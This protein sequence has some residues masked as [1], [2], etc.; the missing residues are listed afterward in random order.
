MRKILFVLVIMIF[1]LSACGQSTPVP[2]VDDV[3]STPSLTP[4]STATLL[5]SVTPT[6]SITPLPTIPTFTP[7]FDVSTI[8]TVTPAGKAECPITKEEILISLPT[9]KE[10]IPGGD[11]LENEYIRPILNYLNS[12]G[13]PMD[14]LEKMEV[15]YCSGKCEMGELKDMTNDGVDEVIIGYPAYIIYSCAGRKYETIFQEGL[16]T[17]HTIYNDLTLNN[18]PELVSAYYP[19]SNHCL[20]LVIREWDGTEFRV[21]THVG[22]NGAYGRGFEITD[23]NGDDLMEIIIT[24]DILSWISPAGMIPNRIKTIIYG[25]NGES[26]TEVQFRFE[27]PQYRFQAVQDA[28]RE[29]NYKHY[30]LA[31]KLYQSAIFSAKLDWWS[32]ER[33][34]FLDDTFSQQYEPTPTKYPTPIA[35]LAEYP[36]LAA[37]AYYRIVLIHLVQGQESEATTTYNTLQQTFGDDPYAHPYIEMAS[38]FWEAY[39]STHKMYDGCA[40][41]IQYAVEH[42]KILIPLG[43]DYHGAQS[44]IYVP[45][46]VCPFR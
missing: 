20:E 31:I 6:A 21:L 9:K 29:T 39:Q 37:Y 28:D 34:R 45:A 19:C 27:A 23:I 2:V 14:L 35:D 22:I 41:A 17:S 16:M 42:P 15:L 5:P 11:E 43:S 18:V 25:W 13:N 12:G 4:T 10:Y 33:Q 44:H 7:T 40:A 1:L 26:Y 32:K 3:T 36:R 8:L 46:D 38:A 24:G 30:D